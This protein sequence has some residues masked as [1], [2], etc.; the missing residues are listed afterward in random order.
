MI[1]WLSLKACPPAA[2]RFVLDADTSILRQEERQKL[3]HVCPYMSENIL[4]TQ[5]EIGIYFMKI[6]FAAIR[7]YCLA[8]KESKFC[9]ATD[10]AILKTG[11]SWPCCSY[12]ICGD[13]PRQLWWPDPSKWDNLFALVKAI[14]RKFWNPLCCHCSAAQ[15]AIEVALR[16][17]QMTDRQQRD[18][19]TENHRSQERW[20]SAEQEE[21]NVRSP[22]PYIDYEQC[23]L[24]STA[25]ARGKILDADSVHCPIARPRSLIPWKA[26]AFPKPIPTMLSSKA[27]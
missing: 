26:Q 6:R 5:K 24:L 14:V 1:S 9:W 7:T 2:I 17:Y 13:C 4:N 15:S 16:V 8:D 3:L 11:R 20:V 25:L 10:L 21:N 18:Q 12:S 19:T 22:N 23:P 27:R